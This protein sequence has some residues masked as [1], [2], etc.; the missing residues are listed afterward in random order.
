MVYLSVAG[1][2]VLLLFGGDLLVRGTVTLARR[3]R[4]V[5]LG[6]GLD[7]LRFSERP[8]YRGWRWFPAPAIRYYRWHCNLGSKGRWAAL[9]HGSDRPASAQAVISMSAAACYLE[10]P[11]GG[12]SR[13]RMRM[14]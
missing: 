13:L 4:V 14:G 3:L 11:M 8:Y 6:R 5:A 10:R 7:V 2:L 12:S 1:G 9:S